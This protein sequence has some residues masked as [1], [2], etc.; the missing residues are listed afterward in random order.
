[1]KALRRMGHQPGRCS[2]FGIAFCIVTTNF[3]RGET[4]KYRS[5]VRLRAEA[6]LYPRQPIE[7]K[8]YALQA[9]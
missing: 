8:S 6:G 2:V 7:G 1:M 3:V 4:H 5:R 9:R